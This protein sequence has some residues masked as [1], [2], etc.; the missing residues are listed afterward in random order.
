MMEMIDFM[1]DALM[2]LLRIAGLGQTGDG[3]F[4]PVCAM[5]HHHAC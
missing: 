1:V 2:I 3:H 5:E 4:S